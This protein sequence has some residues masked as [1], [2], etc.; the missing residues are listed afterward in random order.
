MLLL[1]IVL[2]LADVL[3]HQ[4]TI[5]FIVIIFNYFYCFIINYWLWSSVFTSIIINLVNGFLMLNPLVRKKRNPTRP[6]GSRGIHSFI[7]AISIAP[8]Q[9]LY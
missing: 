9:V 2:P 8:L 4:C 1:L 5:T 6:R 7:Q 3:L